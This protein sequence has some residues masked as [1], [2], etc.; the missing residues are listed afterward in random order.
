MSV[1]RQYSPALVVG[2]DAPL[3]GER[4]AAHGRTPMECTAVAAWGISDEA[5][6][7]EDKDGKYAAP[8]RGWPADSEGEC[9][10]QDG[11]LL[12][13]GGTA[14]TFLQAANS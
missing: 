3:V 4:A 12:P 13:V 10:I 7:R 9:E 5:V 2:H 11:G 6:V 8:L 14:G 1:S